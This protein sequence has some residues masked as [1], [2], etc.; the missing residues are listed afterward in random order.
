MTL[1][2]PMLLYRTKSHKRSRSMSSRGCTYI[3]AADEAKSTHNAALI[4]TLPGCRE[5]LIVLLMRLFL[6]AAGK[7]AY[8]WS[9]RPVLRGRGDLR[10]NRI[11]VVIFVVWKAADWQARM[12]MGGDC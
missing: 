5:V 3:P 12:N 6:S 8:L 11:R 7:Q 4:R 1:Y 2:E 9:W 10:S